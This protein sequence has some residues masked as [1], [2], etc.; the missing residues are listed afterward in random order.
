[1]R[2]VTQPPHAH[3]PIV[4]SD[5][6]FAHEVMVPAN[7]FDEIKSRPSYVPPQ[8]SPE[9]SIP[10]QRIMNEAK[11]VTNMMNLTSHP[12]VK[13]SCRIRLDDLRRELERLTVYDDHHDDDDDA[14]ITKER[15]GNEFPIADFYVDVS[16]ARH[17]F[18]DPEDEKESI[19]E[20][21]FFSHDSHKQIR[22]SHV[23]E[24]HDNLEVGKTTNQVSPL[25]CNLACRPFG[26]GRYLETHIVMCC[27]I[28]TT[29][30]RVVGYC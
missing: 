22:S 26:F 29:A 25:R 19:Q 11:R 4:S 28:G 23:Q 12:Q 5:G 9:R 15:D 2:E 13:A 10:R 30:R 14:G 7:S 3:V 17:F 21:N 6:S 20:L 18:P 24:K 16:P 8:L 1:M 27:T